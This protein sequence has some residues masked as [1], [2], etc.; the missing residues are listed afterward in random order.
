MSREDDAAKSHPSGRCEAAPAG[1]PSAGGP[2]GGPSVRA[3]D[4]PG[5]FVHELVEEDLRQG[6]NGGRVMTR[7]PPEPNGYLHIGHAKSIC[8]NF[9]IAAKFG[10]KCNLRYD[11]TNPETENPEFVESIDRDVKWLGFDWENRKY[12]ASDYFGRLYDFAIQLIKEGKAYVDSR[13]IEEIRGT[14]GDYY[15]AGEN[16]P[17]RD[18]SIAENLALFERMQKGD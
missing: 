4:T 1:D 3:D 8:L 12:F 18:R 14:R 17:Y 10:G 9:G 5:N 13:S 6:K 11:D 16:S 15:Q 7:F 2:A